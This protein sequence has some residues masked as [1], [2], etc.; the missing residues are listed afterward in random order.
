[1]EKLDLAGCGIDDVG[2]RVL[3][4]FFNSHP[5]LA[6]IE[7]KLNNNAITDEGCVHIAGCFRDPRID[8]NN[9]SLQQ[10]YFESP[11]LQIIAISFE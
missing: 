1:M 3:M 10:N 5:T 6:P 8:C 7:C 2:V 4:S 11:G 9:I